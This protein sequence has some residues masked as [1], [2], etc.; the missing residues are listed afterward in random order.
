MRKFLQQEVEAGERIIVGLNAFQ[1]EEETAVP[2]L[3]V[4]PAVEDEQVRQLTRV[5]A[6]RNQEAVRQCLGAL[7]T[8]ARSESANL[9]E[10]V[11]A[12]VRAYCSLGEIC[13]VLRGGSGSIGGGRGDFTA[14]RLAGGKANIIGQGSRVKK[15]KNKA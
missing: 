14:I 1:S 11:L 2:L 10:P 9:M 5:K 15:I 3:R 7:E 8:A 12:A 6:E 13:D 4:D